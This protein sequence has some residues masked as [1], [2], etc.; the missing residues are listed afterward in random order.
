MSEKDLLILGL[1]NVLYGDDGLGVI[2]IELLEQCYNIPEGIYLA[3]GGTLG[4]S[5][6]PLL[7]QSRHIL[8]VDA[9][10]YPGLEPGSM[11]RLE[12]DDVAMAVRDRLSPHQVGV[13]D[14]LEAARL[15]GGNPATV[16]LLGLVP[17]VMEWSVVRSKSVDDG[18]DTLLNAI[19][20]EVQGRG[21]QMVAKS[22]TTSNDRTIHRHASHFGM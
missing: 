15:L 22:A 3:D 9:I 10:R 14:L 11:V 12:G 19:V 20:H 18:I 5:L 4:L 8:I 7:Q 16:T 2:A 17:E 13:S 6:L 21:Y 1:G